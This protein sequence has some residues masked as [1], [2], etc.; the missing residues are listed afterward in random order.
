MAAA[1]MLGI[2]TCPMEGFSPSRISE[3]LDLEGKGLTPVVCC[4][5]GYRSVSDKYA[6]MPKVRWDK[7]AVIQGV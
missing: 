2:D 7:E 1:S 6:T 5:V 3:I 4:P